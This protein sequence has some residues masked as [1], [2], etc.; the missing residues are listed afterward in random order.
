VSSDSTHPMLNS[1]RGGAY[2]QFRAVH[3]ISGHA[4]LNVG[5][6]RQGEFE[7]WLHQ[8]RYYK[9][10]A[11]LALATELH[12]RNSVL[13]TTGDFAEPKAILLDRRLLAR[14]RRGLPN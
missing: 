6:D 13:C 7:T 5:F 2:D 10:L 8:D 1:D 11:R 3:D 14:S 4:M 12:G 9:G